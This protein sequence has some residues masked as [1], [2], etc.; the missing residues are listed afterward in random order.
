MTAPHLLAPVA[1]DDASDHA[2]D[3]AAQLAQILGASMT[4]LHAVDLPPYTC[5]S[6][7]A[8]F[9]PPDLRGTLERHAREELDRRLRHVQATLPDARAVLAMGVPWREIVAAIE[10]QHADLVVMGAQRR[11]WLQHLLLG[12]VAKKVVRASK[13]PVLAV[14]A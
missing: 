2:L 9:P 13:V 7:G 3:V 11:G 5:T 1:F 14:P 6:L 4:V 10:T 8:A 12:G